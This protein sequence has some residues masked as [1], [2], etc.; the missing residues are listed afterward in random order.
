MALKEFISKSKYGIHAIESVTNGTVNISSQE[1]TKNNAFGF[2]YLIFVSTDITAD[3]TFNVQ[4]S[5]DNS[6]WTDID[7]KYLYL[8]A[9]TTT[10][11]VGGEEGRLGGHMLPIAIAGGDF[12]YY[13][14]QM[15]STADAGTA[16]ITQATWRWDNPITFDSAF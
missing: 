8:G 13:R 15:T 1:A 7:S 14:L 4:V 5:S 2:A 12:N 10:I 6:T 11:T 3:V 9:G 16:Y